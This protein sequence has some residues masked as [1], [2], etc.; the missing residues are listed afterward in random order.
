MKLNLK[1][2]VDVEINM[3][4]P[5]ARLAIRQEGSL[6]NAYMAHNSTMNGS[7]L[8]CSISFHIIKQNLDIKRNFV[9][10]AMQSMEKLI[11]DVDA[12]VEWGDIIPAPDHEKTGNMQ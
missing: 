3:E 8:L 6:W 9:A 2:P 5:I 10:L 11:A 4:T 1:N 12:N 7:I